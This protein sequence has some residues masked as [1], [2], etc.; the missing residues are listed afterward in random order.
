VR[1]VAACCSYCLC[2]LALKGKLTPKKKRYCCLRGALFFYFKHDTDATPAGVVPLSY[3]SAH[4][5]VK[6]KDHV[7]VVRCVEAA[8]AYVSTRAHAPLIDEQIDRL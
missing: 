3:F 8:S 1:I 7:L 6:D 2:V 5:L 4:K